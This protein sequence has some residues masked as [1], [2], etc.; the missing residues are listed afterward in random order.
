[1]GEA[2]IVFSEAL[3]K[4]LRHLPLKIKFCHISV[5]FFFIKD[6][7]SS[8][9]ESSPVKMDTLFLKKEVAS[10]SVT[11][12][13]AEMVIN[14]CRDKENKLPYDIWWFGNRFRHMWELRCPLCLSLEEDR[15]H[16][17]WWFVVLLWAWREFYR[18]Y[19]TCHVG[20]YSQCNHLECLEFQSLILWV[21]VNILEHQDHLPCWTT[22]LGGSWPIS[23]TMIIF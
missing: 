14:V 11:Y 23:A 12:S 5:F 9:S 4:S 17:K 7:F 10:C 20:M 6:S 15:A 8:P 21:F 18:F 3:Q 22:K 2:S 13:Q 1:M 16:I 19:S